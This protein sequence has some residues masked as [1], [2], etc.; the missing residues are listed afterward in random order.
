MVQVK[1]ANHTACT[2]ECI[3]DKT[4][5]NVYETFSADECL[6]VCDFDTVPD[7]NPCV[8]PFQWEQTMCGC[9]CSIQPHTCGE[10]KD[11]NGKLCGCFC[12]LEYQQKCAESMK[13]LDEESCECFAPTQQ[14]ADNV[15]GNMS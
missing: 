2:E 5:C 12:K 11:Y 1:L 6:C 3:I 14:L 8:S 10:K 7:P 4:A 15:G 9:R 13:V